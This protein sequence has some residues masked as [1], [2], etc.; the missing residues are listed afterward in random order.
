MTASTSRSADLDVG[1]IACVQTMT[2]VDAAGAGRFSADPARVGDGIQEV[3]TLEVFGAEQTE[4]HNRFLA[5]RRGVCPMRL[6]GDGAS[7]PPRAEPSGA[8]S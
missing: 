1:E 6:T 4:R 5:G 3:R 8:T 2:A 7:A